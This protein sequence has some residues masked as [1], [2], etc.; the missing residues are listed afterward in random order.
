MIDQLDTRRAQVYIESMIVEVSGG[1]AADFGFQ[2]Q[3][4]LGQSGDK[5][6]LVA[7]TNFTPSSGKGNLLTITGAQATEAHGSQA[8]ARSRVSEKF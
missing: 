4:L 6:G 2:W 7:G 3:G 5:T 1:D 8:A